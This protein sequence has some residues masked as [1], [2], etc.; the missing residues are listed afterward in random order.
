MESKVVILVVEEAAAVA[1]AAAAVA[2]LGSEMASS[3]ARIS[4]TLELVEYWLACTIILNPKNE[5]STRSED[6]RHRRIPDP[7]VCY[8]IKTIRAAASIS[9]L[10]RGRTPSS[11]PLREA[12]ATAHCSTDRSP[13]QSALSSYLLPPTSTTTHFRRIQQQHNS[14]CSPAPAQQSYQVP[15]TR[16]RY[17]FSSPTTSF[18]RHERRHQRLAAE[19]E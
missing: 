16:Y 1:A 13:S 3:H 18:S 8:P 2:K 17:L 10:E 7:A 11:S 14:N 9:T 15:G 19:A 4:Q 6:R 12:P 5:T